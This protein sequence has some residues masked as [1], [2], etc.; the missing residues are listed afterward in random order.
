MFTTLS[1]VWFD[2]W[3]DKTRTLQV[4]LVIALGA[5]GVGLVIGGRNL[6][7]GAVSDSWQAAQP[8]NISL[9]VSPPLTAEQVDAVARI[10]GVA[11][12]EGLYA[13]AV[14]WRLVGS[15]EWETGL[16][17]ARDDYERQTMTLDGLVSGQ[18]PTRNTAAIGVV[19]VGE[20]GAAEGDTVE[21]RFGDSTRMF[22]LVGTIDPIGPQPSFQEA[23]YVDGR[24]FA[25]L[26]GRDTYNI[27]QTRDLVY[28]EERA[29]ATD[30]RIQ[31]YFETIGVD[32]VGMSFPLQERVIPPD[33]PPAADI[34]NA[35]FLILGIIGV[36]VVI[37]GIF[38]VYNSVSAIVMQQ[39]DQIGVM[40]AIGADSWQ[41][42]RGYL[43]LVISYG[44]LAAIVSIPVGAMSAFGL[45]NFFADFLNLEID[46]FR[47]D[48]TAVLIQVL[49]SLVAPLLAALVPLL[50]GMRITVREAI[51]AYGLTGA[52]S[53]IDR[54]VAQAKNIPYAVLLTIGNTFRNAK[55]VVVIEIALVVAGAIFMMVMGVR[56]AARFTFGDKLTAIH[57]YNVA[58]S[59]EQPERTVRV[60]PM[61]AAVDAVEQV[62]AWLAL[63]GSVRLAAQTES[64]VT[65]ARITIFG[66]NPQTDFYRPEMIDGRWLQL[67]DTNAVVVSQRI[68]AEKGFELGDWITLADSEARELTAQVVGI[69]YD[70]ATNTS[71]HLPLAT[72]QRAW[73]FVGQTNTVWVQTVGAM[74]VEGETAVADSIAQMLERRGIAV[75]PGS[76]FGDVST[77]AISEQA[78]DGYDIIIQ[79]LV[80][81]AVVIALVGGVG[82]SGVLS[83]SVLE[84]RREIGVMRAIGASSWQVIRLFVG[85]GVLLGVISWLIALPL[86][87]PAAYG[88]T[89]Y[90]LSFVLNQQLAY[91]FTPAGAGLWLVIITM[92]AIIAS[93]LPARGAAKVSVRESL[94]YQ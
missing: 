4:T 94:S 43:I 91:Q 19:S 75:A 78:T 5:I 24:T 79:L 37:L 2:L 93:A 14:E 54:L 66:Q 40:K 51:G 61:V 12:A 58:L 76:V 47:V 36:V 69:H 17:N 41:V 63:P 90:G 21:L 53:L 15:E 70:P 8:P 35:L 72:V 52:V 26:T 45:Q 77:T 28:D 38:L 62:D 73:G 50:V 30:L 80:V 84:R 34:L 25:R 57:N 56:D 33:I 81:M 86:S 9:S 74:G 89:T 44:L 46:S 23:F 39:V 49:I 65:D 13:T 11:E 31:D 48:G 55:R 68:S 16:L 10:D 7:A 64:E 32:S 29:I 71:L 42:V 87:V 82:L 67:D 20:T 92:L 1:K 27:I 85:E 59:L 6:V 3:Q 18:W 22:E 83:L 88:L 60:V